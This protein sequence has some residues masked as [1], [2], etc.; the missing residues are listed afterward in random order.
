M[1]HVD[2]RWKGR[3]GIG[4]FAKEVVKRLEMPW[5]PLGGN[6]SP[7][8]RSDIVHLRRLRLPREDIVYNP[9]FNAGLTR[10]KQLLT[11]HDLIHLQVKSESSVAKT[12]YYNNVVRAAIQRAGTAMTV[13]E[14]SA[15][16]LRDW[17][18]TPDVDV[19]VVGCGRSEAFTIEG[20]R[21]K[22]SRPTFL[23]VGNLKPHKN[24]SIVMEA[25][26][27][28]PDYDLVIVGGDPAHGS[29]LASELG[30]ETQ[31]SFRN[32]ISD[33]ELARLYRGV[34][35]VIQPSLVEGF[36]LPALEA[37]SCGTRVAY[38]A[39]CESVTEI[40]AGKG[41]EV[42]DASNASEWVGA[43]DQLLGMADGGSLAMPP[44]WGKSYTW[45][46]VASKVAEVVDGATSFPVDIPS[47]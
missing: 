34:D 2:D 37:M 45:D 11:I 43:F 7:M 24:V 10:A 15:R 25:I 42:R 20:P 31:V 33:S 19:I 32:G 26:S 46:S 23:Y 9:G 3:H 27:K 40:C 21:H 13:S 8:S 41:V 28:R 18:D 6:T 38:W 30:A 22:F 17:L 39:E 5:A 16:V 35:G 44:A 36:G 12:F 1:L 29:T 47:T 4:R 14:T